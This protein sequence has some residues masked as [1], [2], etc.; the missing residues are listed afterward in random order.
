MCGACVRVVCEYECTC[1]CVWNLCL[2]VNSKA[3]GKERGGKEKTHLAGGVQDTVLGVGGADVGDPVLPAV[4]R[5]GEHARRCRHAGT[6]V[7][8]MCVLCVCMPCVCPAVHRFGEHARRCRHAGTRVSCMCVCMSCVC[9]CRVCV[10]MSCVCVSC[11]CVC[12]CV[13]VC[14]CVFV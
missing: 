2:G 10:C 1:V 9:V 8:C 14:V 5:F 11:V 6:H 4:H 13:C 7:S 3:A 12:A